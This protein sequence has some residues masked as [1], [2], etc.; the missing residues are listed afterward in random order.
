MLD[1]IYV[2]QLKPAKWGFSKS[3][4]LFT[5]D[6]IDDLHSFA[7]RIGLKKHWFQNDIRLPHYDLTANKQRLA[8]SMGAQLAREGLVKEI[9]K[10]Q[11][12]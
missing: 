4:H 3:C 12:E 11:T 2:D 9:I 8:I 1:N 5:T 10:C 6:N 7:E